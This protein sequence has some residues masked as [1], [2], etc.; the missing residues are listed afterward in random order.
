MIQRILI[1]DDDVRHR[2]LLSDYL[3]SQ[4]FKC[5]V[6]ANAVEMQKQLVRYVCHLIL[7][8]VNMPGE[9]GLEICKRLRAEENLIPIILLTARNEIVDRVIGLEFG[10]DDYL[11]KPF[12]LR[13]LLARIN[14]VLRRA[15]NLSEQSLEAIDLKLQFGPY[16]LNGR[17]RSLL[18]DNQVVSLS[19]EE[20]SLLI[21]LASK[22]GKAFTR[23]QLAHQVINDGGDHKPEQRNIDML[24]SRLR[25]RIEVTPAEPRYIH[26]IRGVGYAF[27]N[28]FSKAS[29]S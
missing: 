23:N 17:A 25:K 1:V 3:E 5:L 4:G 29:G 2:A 27:T 24:V 12:D 10:A 18:C 8:D 13:E 11:P 19:T 14:S 28:E 9:N 15:P 22:P 26:T 20:L 16:F 21:M 6:A 7:L